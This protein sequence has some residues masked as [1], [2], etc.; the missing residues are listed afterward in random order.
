MSIFKSALRVL[1]RHKLYVLIYLVMMTAMGVIIS[2]QANTGGVTEYTAAKPN[3]AVIDRDGSQISR[4]IA[5]YVSGSGTEVQVDDSQ[6]AIQDATAEDAASYILVI[7]EGYG[8][9]LMSAA[10]DGQDAPALRTVI[11]YQGAAGSL[12]DIKVKQYLQSLYGYASATGADQEEVARLASDAMSREADVSIVDTGDSSVS[13]ALVQYFMWTEYPLFCSCAVC[14]AVLMKSLNGD[15]VRRRLLAAPTTSFSR[16]LQEFAACVVAGI[17]AWAFVVIVGL[18]F[19][20]QALV[21]NAPATAALLSLPSLAYAMVSVGVG[22]LLGQMGVG[23]ELAN[24]LANVGG[25]VMSFMGGAWIDLSIVG[26]GIL[27]VAH[28]APSFWAT[29]AIDKVLGIETAYTEAG[30]EM[31]GCLGIVSLYAIVFVIV[32]FVVGRARLQC[33]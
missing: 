6:R 9:D 14:I 19:Y 12:M 32:A 31:W 25:M 4:S 23:E 16:S 2:S 18:A 28:L 15:D 5:A 1:W 8:D 20:G 29:Q 3:V 27:S 17:V 33:S 7:P 24:A 11:S 21:A 26:D 10:A 13:E 22:F 30:V